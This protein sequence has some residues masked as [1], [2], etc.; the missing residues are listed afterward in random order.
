MLFPIALALLAQAATPVQQL[1]VSIRDAN[2]GEP[3]AHAPVAIHGSNR[4]G[5]TDSDGEVF[6]DGLGLSSSD[7]LVVMSSPA[8]HSPGVARVDMSAGESSAVLYLPP[9]KQMRSMLIRAGDRANMYYN[10]LSEE[11]SGQV[12][13]HIPVGAMPHDGMV[14]LNMY[15]HHAFID[16]ELVSDGHML[17]ACE[18]RLLT[19]EGVPSGFSFSAPIS[20]DLG[21]VMS[22]RMS[23]WGLKSAE[24]F[25][26]DPES[27]RF[28]LDG[29]VAQIDFDADTVELLVTSPGVYA[30]AES[31]CARFPVETSV[32]YECVGKGDTPV[33]HGMAT[34]HSGWGGLE[35]GTVVARTHRFRETLTSF[36]DGDQISAARLMLDIEAAFE[37]AVS[38]P[39]G[40]DLAVKAHQSFEPKWTRDALVFHLCRNGSARQYLRQKVVTMSVPIPGSVPLDLTRRIPF[41][42][43]IGWS[44]QPKKMCKD[45][46]CAITPLNHGPCSGM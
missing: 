29:D 10:F 37:G 16:G 26:F 7:Q 14:E 28:E 20:I 39:G 35:K 2:T 41:E 18:V 45:E 32:S 15:P 46:R 17:G 5:V 3:L 38:F 6:L 43:A 13:V 40:Q 30:F 23:E 21:N 1:K 36:L 27:M 25:S 22:L 19:R 33:V 24:Q 44:L 34:A 11:F 4:M 42:M 31:N 9:R 12:E 8:S